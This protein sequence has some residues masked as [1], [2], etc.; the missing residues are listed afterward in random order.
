MAPRTV[1]ANLAD[2]LQPFTLFD[3]SFSDVGSLGVMPCIATGTN[4][5]VLTPLVNAFAPAPAYANLHQFSFVAAITS[6]AAVTLNI[7]GLGALPLY[8]SDLTQASAGDLVQGILYVVTY[9][10][11]LNSGGG[12][13]QTPAV[14]TTGVTRVITAAGDVTVG[15]ADALIILNKTV[16]EATNFIMPPSATKLGGVLIVNWKA[17]AGAFTHTVIPNGIELFNGG[18]TTWPIAGLGASAAFKPISTGL[19][20]AV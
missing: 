4:A 18:Q 8:R 20:Y 5:V 17:D 9:N 12:G 14:N 3:Q 15:I 11:A 2:G 7:G 10:A 13:F 1:Y 6:T 16:L 19:G